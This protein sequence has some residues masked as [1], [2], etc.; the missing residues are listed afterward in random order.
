MEANKIFDFLKNLFESI[1]KFT[2]DNKF[3]VCNNSFKF[4]SEIRE[5]L[6]NKENLSFE[7]VEEN[8]KKKIIDFN[9]LRMNKQ[10]SDEIE[11]LS[12]SYFQT[13]DLIIRLV[14]PKKKISIPNDIRQLVS[15][16]S[17][18]KYEIHIFQLV[19]ATFVKES[20]S[21]INF[22][23][24]NNWPEA[25]EFVVKSGG[26]MHLSLQKVI[27]KQS[28]LEKKEIINNISKELDKIF[29]DGVE[30][31]VVFLNT[32]QKMLKVYVILINSLTEI[33]VRNF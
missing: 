25:I 24:L 16:M 23:H 10:E 17:S 1:Q 19:C 32:Y 8:V 15:D 22:P 30:D 13:I 5:L 3:F 9:K 33:I 12:R 27:D 4:M 26:T 21:F 28:A 2:I 18:L 14:N 29:N 20:N 7:I 31:F 6:A 11:L